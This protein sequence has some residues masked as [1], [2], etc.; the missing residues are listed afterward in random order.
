MCMSCDE[1]TIILKYCWA[2]ETN[3]CCTNT[4]NE[5]FR[6][7]ARKQPELVRA[8]DYNGTGGENNP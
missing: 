7:G 2:Y 8:I 1:A 3:L 4:P 6:C 5:V